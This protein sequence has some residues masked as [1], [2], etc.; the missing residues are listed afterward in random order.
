[1]SPTLPTRTY[2]AKSVDEAIAQAR[3]EIG[4]EAMLLNTRK[5][6]IEENPSGG[7]EVVFCVPE[8]QHKPRQLEERASGARPSIP[9]P[10][11]LAADLGRLHSQMD[12]IRNLLLRPNKAQFTPVRVAPELADMYD[13][14]IAA[15]VEPALSK[16]IVDRL[17]A[18]MSLDG[19]LARTAVRRENPGP[20]GKASLDER[21]RLEAFV[22]EELERRV[23]IAPRLG[24]NGVVL[25]GPPG[26]GKTTTAAKLASVVAD[27]AETRPVRILSLDTSARAVRLR[28]MAEKLGIALT[29]VASIHLLP[30]L[31][32]DARKTEFLLIDTPG[33]VAADIAAAEAAAAALAECPGIDT[34]LVVPGYMKSLDLRHCIQRFEVF[35]PSKILVTK[36]DE[37]QT[38]GSVFSEASRAR[39]AL[40][41]LAHGPRMTRDI[42]PASSEDLLALAL[43]RCPARPANVA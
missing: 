36:L 4:P 14:L 26:A 42:R 8:G 20:R 43:E 9:A 35:R 29:K 24:Q 12:E 19:Y 17:E 23:A 31:I 13:Y 6:G 27:L 21:E 28:E 40:S 16:D 41:F 32:A 15:D 2:L 34:H 1:M 7:Y 39:L 18:D 25:V 11:D 5:V 30:S 37:T 10:E 38:F 22:L 3:E 33:Y